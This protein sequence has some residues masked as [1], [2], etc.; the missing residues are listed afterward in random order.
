MAVGDED[1]KNLAGGF[2]RIDKYYLLV[3]GIDNYQGGIATLSNAVSDAKRVARVLQKYRFD[4]PIFPADLTNSASICLYDADA[5]WKNISDSLEAI[6][7]KIG[8]NDALLIYFAGHGVRRTNNNYYI[9]PSDGVKGQ[10]ATYMQIN[11]LYDLFA[12]YPTAKKCRDLLIILDSCYAGKALGGYGERKNLPFSRDI[13]TSCL[14]KQPADDGM[15]GHGS[16]FVNELVN[17]LEE[18]NAIKL[19]FD[20]AYTTLR[21]RF[22]KSGERQFLEQRLDKGPIPGMEYGSGTFVFEKTETVK[23]EI[24]FLKNSLIDHLNFEHQRV[25]VKESYKT[26]QN[27]LNI[28]TTQGSSL[29][30]QRV[31]SKIIFRWLDK[32]GSLKVEPEKCFIEDFIKI[33]QDTNIWDKLYA[34]IRDEAGKMPNDK[35]VIHQWYFQKL[36]SNDPLTN[37][38]CHVF[39][40]IGFEIGGNDMFKSIETFCSEFSEMFLRSVSTLDVSKKASLGK[41]FIII[42]DERENGGGSH[43]ELLKQISNKPFNFIPTEFPRKIKW[44]DAKDWASLF[45]DDDLSEKIQLLKEYHGLCKLCGDEDFEASY[46]D[47][48]QKL[49]HYCEYNK[50]DIAELNGYL[51]DFTTKN[52]L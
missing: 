38:L 16:V 19:P 5:T 18:N 42:S 36:E 48:V 24:K 31:I 41:M 10:P 40:P 45:T 47:F 4:V 51:Y 34:Q 20:Q 26:S 21:K 1:D 14:E 12:D 39:L 27:S 28:I 11:E 25:N 30:V 17:L 22:D 3:V 52:L 9:V 6:H 46:E 37:K 8:V 33:D 29:H 44:N 49:C 35:E 32:N 13:L 23:P 2:P 15:R 7:Q 50:N 43:K